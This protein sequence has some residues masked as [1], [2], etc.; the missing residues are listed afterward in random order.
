MYKYI[1]S[2]SSSSVYLPGLFIETTNLQSTSQPP[3]LQRQSLQLQRS[4]S[5]ESIKR[6]HP[7]YDTQHIH[8]V[9]SIS[10]HTTD[11]TAIN[12]AMLFALGDARKG[13]R[14]EGTSKL[15][16]RGGGWDAG[17]FGEAVDGFEDEESRES[18]AE[19]G[20]AVGRSKLV[21]VSFQGSAWEKVGVVPT[22]VA[23]SVMYVPPIAGSEIFAWNA[24]IATNMMVLVNVEYTCSR[25]MTKR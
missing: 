19:V 25:I 21:F 24:E 3:S 13:L 17:G 6:D 23:R 9:I 4:R 14:D 8:I 10:I 1:E 11:A 5:D 16:G 7:K 12:T 15:F 22:Y 2:V 18:A 20:D